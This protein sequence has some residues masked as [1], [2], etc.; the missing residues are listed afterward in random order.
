MTTTRNVSSCRISPSRNN[1]SSGPTRTRSAASLSRPSRS[2]SHSP[3]AGRLRSASRPGFIQCPR[4]HQIS[5]CH[6]EPDA[7]ILI[8]RKIAYWCPLPARLSNRG[9][10]SMTAPGLAPAGSHRGE[11]PWRRLPG[12]PW[13]AEI[14]IPAPIG[15]PPRERRPAATPDVDVAMLRSIIPGSASYTVTVATGTNFDIS[16]VQIGRTG[17]GAA[18]ALAIDGTLRTDTLSYISTS[19]TPTVLD[20]NPG[21]VF[22]IRTSILD[23]GSHIETLTISG[24]NAGGHLEL[25]SLIGRQRQCACQFRERGHRRPQHRRH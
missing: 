24:K 21:G 22:D 19:N 6:R 25:G 5:L 18:P 4:I 13:L 15:T 8:N 12:R 11:R 1:S 10:D 2:A 23:S 7:L 17:D 20:I 14:G 3:S 16:Q 9:R